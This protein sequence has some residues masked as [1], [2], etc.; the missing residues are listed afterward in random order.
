MLGLFPLGE[1]LEAL[2]LF[3]LEGFGGLLTVGLQYVIAGPH[4][5]VLLY[6]PVR[7]SHPAAGAEP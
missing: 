5:L 3:S 6:C 4:D 1:R 7:F 2:E